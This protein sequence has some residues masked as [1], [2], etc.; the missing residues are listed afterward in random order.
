MK[1]PYPFVELMWVDAA[2]DH[3]WQGVGENQDS[4]EELALTRGWRVKENDAFIWIAATVDEQG[5][6]N[7]RIKIP[8]AMIKSQREVVIPGKRGVRGA[9]KQKDGDNKP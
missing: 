5:N 1:I 2:T 6:H 4:D 3:G 8:K 9:E 7:Q